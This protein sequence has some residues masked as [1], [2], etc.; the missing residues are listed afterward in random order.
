MECKNNTHNQIDY[1]LTPRRFKSSIITTSTRTYPGADIGSNHDLVLCN[2]KLKLCIRKSTVTNRIRYDLD[3]L[4]NVTTDNNYKVKL[5]IELSRVKINENDIT[6][7]YSM[8]EKAI[9]LTA[10][11]VIRKYRNKKQPWITLDILDLCDDRRKLKEAT[12]SNLEMKENYKQINII[13]RKL[14][15]NAKENWIQYQCTSINEDISKERA[16]KKAY[17]TL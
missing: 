8:I 1:I 6:E 7:T 10:D 17:Q 11:K 5:G 13:I 2:L 14:M 9:L 12:E 16:N 3:K 15:K 4:E